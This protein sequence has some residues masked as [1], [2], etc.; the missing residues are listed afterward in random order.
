MS[1]E[2]SWTLCFQIYK[3]WWVQGWSHLLIGWCHWTPYW[4]SC[5]CYILSVLVLALG[6]LLAL[7]L[8]TFQKERRDKLWNPYHQACMAETTRR[9]DQWDAEH[10]SPSAVG[11]IFV[12]L[13]LELL[14]RLTFQ[15]NKSGAVVWTFPSHHCVSCLGVDAI[16][17]LSFLSTWFF[18]CSERFLAWYLRFPLSPKLKFP[19]SNLTRK[20]RRRTTMW[21]CYLHIGW[22]NVYIKISHWYVAKAR[23]TC[24]STLS[25]KIEIFS[26]WRD[27]M[28]LI[29]HCMS[30]TIL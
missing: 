22:W 20:G 13:S 19:N 25:Q 17:G 2:E 28:K 1:T 14:V 26:S 15:G 9:L 24:N 29:L 10:P 4:Q 11:L 18:L 21:M 5:L 12:F 6:P 7:L 3:I 30:S 8:F 27:N 16:C 23:F